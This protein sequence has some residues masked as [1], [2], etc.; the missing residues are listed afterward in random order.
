M[1]NIRRARPDPILGARNKAGAD[2]VAFDVAQH[3]KQVVVFLDGKAFES[4]LP[5]VSARMIVMMVASD[6]CGEQPGHVVAELAVFAWPKGEVE[7]V[8]HQAKGQQADGNMLIG[9]VQEFEEGVVVAILVKDGAPSVP[10]IEHVVAMP[11]QGDSK[12]SGR[13]VHYGRG[14]PQR[15]SKKYADTLSPFLAQTI[16]GK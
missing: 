9:L 10:A 11:A 12:S 3:S 8:G 7:M 16:S 15:Q 4:P 5:N 13:G 1:R 2:G 14:K 6:M